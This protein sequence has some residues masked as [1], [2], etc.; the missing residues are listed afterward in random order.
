MKQTNFISFFRSVRIYRS[1]NLMKWSSQL[2]WS[3]ELTDNEWTN[4]EWQ[5][6]W[7]DK[8]WWC[9]NNK[10]ILW[11]Q[12]MRIALMKDDEIFLRTKTIMITVITNRWKSFKKNHMWCWCNKISMCFSTSLLLDRN[13]MSHDQK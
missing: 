12:M 6:E 9:N 7:Y 10:N 11:W 3:V 1:H 4:N 8:W 2:W 13:V 5:W